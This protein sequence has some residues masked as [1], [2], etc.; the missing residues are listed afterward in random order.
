MTVGVP[1]TW[2][3]SFFRGPWERVQLAGYPDERTDAEVTFIV[4]A[5]QLTAGAR[6]LDV[7]CGEGRHSVEL[8]RRGFEPVGVDFNPVALEAGRVRARDKRVHVT[9]AE[10]DARTFAIDR[11]CDAAICFYGSFGYFDDADNLRFAKRVAESLRPGGQ[12]LVDVQVV[13]TVLPD[14]RARDWWWMTPEQT[15]MVAEHRRFDVDTCRVE[16]T[17]TFIG[18]GHNET[19]SFSIRLYTCKELRELLR[20]AGFT[21]FRALETITAEP[22]CLGSERLSLIAHLPP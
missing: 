13:E 12:F 3:Q 11:P 8:A 7:P 15:T 18:E 20:E 9:F 6:V 16:G 14:F 2:W 21:R 10:G 4:E 5:M 22:F 17:Y 1:G 19:A